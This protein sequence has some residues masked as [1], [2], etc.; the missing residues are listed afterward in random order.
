[1]R[2]R[3][4]EQPKVK[5]KSFPQDKMSISCFSLHHYVELFIIGSNLRIEIDA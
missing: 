4:Y 1:M 2:M 3:E 5:I